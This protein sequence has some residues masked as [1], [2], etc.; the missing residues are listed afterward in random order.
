MTSSDLTKMKVLASIECQ[1]LIFIGTV[2]LG[3]R[4]MQKELVFHF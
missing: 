3:P 4:V 1:E 2:F